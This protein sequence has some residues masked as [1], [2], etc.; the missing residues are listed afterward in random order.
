M[1]KHTTHC[2][3]LFLIAFVKKKKKII[4]FSTNFHSHLKNSNYICLKSA[5]TTIF[6][7]LNFNTINKIYKA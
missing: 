1:N 4:K 2:C 3:S 5:Q 7:C 6:L